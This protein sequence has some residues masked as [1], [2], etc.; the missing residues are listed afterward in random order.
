[1]RVGAGS[2][3]LTH[4]SPA[5]RLI[6]MLRMTHDVAAMRIAGALPIYRRTYDYMA[7]PQHILRIAR[8]L[9]APEACT[10]SHTADAPCAARTMGIGD[11][12]KV[13]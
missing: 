11:T 9:C 2:I 8:T 7:H 5:Q 3:F 13:H 12:H 1:M 4:K 10:R 6:Q